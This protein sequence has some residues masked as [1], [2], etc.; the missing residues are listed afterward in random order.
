MGSRTVQI[1]R[2]SAL[3]GKLTIPKLLD[4]VSRKDPAS[5]LALKTDAGD[6][7]FSRADAN[8][9]LERLAFDPVRFRLERCEVLDRLWLTVTTLYTDSTGKTFHRTREFRQLSLGQQQSIFLAL[10]LSAET[11]TLLIIDQPE[12]KLDGEFIYQSVFPF[13]VVQRNAGWL[14]LS[15][16][17]R[18]LP[19][20]A[21]RSRSLC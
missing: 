6:A 14:S 18:T 5:I 17:M 1:P 19:F 21:T 8:A 13:C 11:H 4:A 9:L 7:V 16:T 15:R 2:A 20:S 3:I 10:M 12:D